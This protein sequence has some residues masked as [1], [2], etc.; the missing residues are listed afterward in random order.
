MAA[1]IEGDPVRLISALN[2]LETHIL[3][4]SRFGP[5]GGL[6]ADALFRELGVE[7]VPLDAVLVQTALSAWHRYGKGHHPAGLNMG[8]C[9]AYATAVLK[10]Q[11]LLCKGKDFRAT[12]IAR[13]EY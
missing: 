9:C 1:G 8:D 6:M 5:P 10:N 11:K 2:W 4:N 13:V 7:I 3:L 12:D